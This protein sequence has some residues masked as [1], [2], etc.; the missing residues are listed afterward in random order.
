VLSVLPNQ[1]IHIHP[2]ATSKPPVGKP[3]NGCGVCC[4]V[5]PC[6]LGVVLSGRRVGAC[7]A[8]R[9]QVESGVYRCGAIIDSEAVLRH[10][11]IP[12]LQGLAPMLAPLLRRLSRRWIAVGLGCDSALEVAI[13]L[14]S[15]RQSSK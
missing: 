2:K 14:Q 7:D 10:A 5:E 6:P 13:E 1:I 9:W 4:L 3:C 12:W 15:D 8:I 11:L